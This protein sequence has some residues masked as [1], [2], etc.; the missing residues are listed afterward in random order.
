MR[1]KRGE[2]P[3]TE[4]AYPGSA[5]PAWPFPNRPVTYT[6]SGTAALEAI[7]LD[8]DLAEGAVIVP[9]FICRGAF[10]SLFDRYEIE[11]IVVDV[12]PE[13][14]QL[15]M[16]AVRA[17]LERADA[18]L[19]DHAF[20]HL[21]PADTL[22]YLCERTDTILIEDGARALHP[23]VGRYGEYALYSFA[24]TT[25]LFG[26]GAVVHGGGTMPIE[27]GTVSIDTVVRTMH[28][29]L[30]H[31]VAAPTSVISWYHAHRSRNG[32]G[33]NSSGTQP[34]RATG[35]D[36]ITRWR[37]QRYIDRQFVADHR[38]MHRL[39]GAL[40]QLLARYGFGFSRRVAVG[41]AVLQAVAPAD[42]NILLE[43]LT[44]RGYP[45]HAVWSDPWG[46]AHGTFPAARELADRVITFRLTEWTT[47]DVDRLRT[48]MPQLMALSA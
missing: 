27:P 26:G 38:R 48:E 6:A 9:A 43:R 42:R 10:A 36:P 35:I 47:H 5:L 22:C 15:N 40:Q 46:L 20:G 18:V 12:D 41:H 1:R 32:A 8:A 33:Q 44:D 2:Q 3:I 25:S 24:K 4:G 34:H 30:P 23:A 28:D 39:R 14:F 7:I 31:D 45:V 19:V 13:T 37:F 16:R 11:P 21:V 29:L 17:R